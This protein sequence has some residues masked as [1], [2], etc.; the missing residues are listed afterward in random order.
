MGRVSSRKLIDFS[1][2]YHPWTVLLISHFLAL[3][4][5]GTLPL[6]PGFRCIRSS[7]QLYITAHKNG[8]RTILKNTDDLSLWWMTKIS[9]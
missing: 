5:Q 7:H 3:A 2:N 8:I 1:I 9:Y 4:L 6:S